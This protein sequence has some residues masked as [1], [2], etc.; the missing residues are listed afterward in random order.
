MA[1]GSAI[2]PLHNNLSSRLLGTLD[3]H[4]GSTSILAP[5]TS[6][7]DYIQNPLP[8]ADRQ[9]FD[10]LAIRMKQITGFSTDR[11]SYDSYGALAD[12]LY[13]QFHSYSFV[14]EIYGGPSSALS[15]T[16]EYFNPVDL[17]T[18]NVAINNAI[19]SAMFML[20]NEAFNVVVPE[21]STLSLFAIIGL[22]LLGRRKRAA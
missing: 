10:F 19:N 14:E 5:W 9:K 13:E 11:L 6:P 17:N 3:F 20:S 4:S 2:H 1:S 15:N 18:G 22:S 8:L 7:T 16:F 12:S 21:P